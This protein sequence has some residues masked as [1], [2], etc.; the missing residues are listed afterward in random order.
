MTP[1]QHVAAM[2][3]L[4]LGAALQGSV[5]F[6]CNLVA[7]PLLVLIDPTL[8]PAP[9]ITANLTLNLA[10]IRRERPD[11]AWRE[12]RWPIIGQLPGTV[13]GAA[14][15]AAAS[16][17]NLT[18]FLAVL[19]LAAVGVSLRRTPVRRTPAT[20]A[21]AG[22]LSGFMGTAAGIGGP[23]VA[24]L[25]QHASGLEIRSAISRFFLVSSLCS[26]AVLT[27]FGLFDLG[28]V[29]RGVLLVPGIAVGF[30]ASG[31]LLGR[32]EHRHVRAAI[33]VISAASGL[34]ALARGLAAG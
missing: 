25:Y 15:L 12:A 30:W 19:T 29:V 18:V 20:L 31:P 4:A 28:S 32:V 10:M 23:P 8:V 17:R 26:V 33:L 1:I 16:T 9:L 6:G 7:A 11:G 34:L 27:V 14:V 2:A 5:G 24:L 3:A 21:V 22:A 13:A